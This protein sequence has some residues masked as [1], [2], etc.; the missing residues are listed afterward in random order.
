MSAH[1]DN[2]LLT[3]LA[4]WNVVVHLLALVFALFGMRPGTAAGD[5]AHRQEYLAAYPLGWTLG[6]G[7]WLVCALSQ[8][9]FYGALLRHLPESGPFPRL[10]VTIAVAGVAV[11]IFCDTVWITVIPQLAQQGE[12]A[13]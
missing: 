5:L 9:A 3:S 6:W 11:D 2:R 4:W 10:A 1:A 8:V 12:Q 13:K 7:T